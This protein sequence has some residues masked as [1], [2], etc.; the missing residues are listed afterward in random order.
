VL[1]IRR[2]KFYY[3][4]SGNIT[5]L[6]GRPVNG[7]ATYRCDDTGLHN[8]MCAVITAHIL[9]CKTVTRI[10][11]IDFGWDLFLFLTAQFYANV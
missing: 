5:P 7:T 2:S 1:I 8:N 4:A 9:S 6:S 11:T 3:T 10:L